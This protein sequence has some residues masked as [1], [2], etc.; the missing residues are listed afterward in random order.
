MLKIQKRTHTC[1]VVSVGV[2]AHKNMR[3][4]TPRA[5][6]E[7]AAKQR[8]PR[9]IAN[10]GP[11]ILRRNIF[12]KQPCKG[13]YAIAAG[14]CPPGVKVGGRIRSRSV[15]RCNYHLTISIKISCR[16]LSTAARRRNSRRQCSPPHIPPTKQSEKTAPWP[17]KPLLLL[18]RIDCSS[19]LMAE[20]GVCSVGGVAW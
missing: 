10:G 5:C 4:H 8:T 1:V 11:N 15:V 2:C 17:A 19:G 13:V 12:S 18:F 14:L 20:T 16:C 3:P 7:M 9:E 6:M